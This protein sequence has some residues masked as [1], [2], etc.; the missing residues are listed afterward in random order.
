M[1]PPSAMP[2]RPR[3]ARPRHLVIIIAAVVLALLI[4]GSSI[5]GIY[6][7]MLW[8]HWGGLGEIWRLV[9]STKIVLEVIFFVVAFALMYGCLHLVDRV[10]D[11]S[12]FVTQESELVQHYRQSVARFRVWMRLGL[13]LLIAVILA[14]GTSGQWQHWL[15]YQHA[16]AFGH[17]DPIF[18]RDLS[19][20][21]FRMPFLSFLVDWVFSA[22]VVSVIIT[23]AS[24][25]LN[26]ALHI[27]FGPRR[28][29]RI[30][31]RAVAHI[32]LLLSL[33]ALERAWAYYFVDRFSLE[34]SQHGAVF[35]ATYT[36]VHVRL[37]A[38]TLLA[39]VSL[40]GFVLLAFNVYQRSITMPLIA[41]G[42]WIFL[43]ITIGA[44]YPSLYQA[45]KVTPDQ[46]SL[47]QP[48]IQRNIDATRAAMN[49][50]TITNQ[51]FPANQD[52]TA[53]VLSSY[54]QTLNDA[55]LWD[56]SPSQATYVKLQDKRSYYSL[57]PLVIDRYSLN[58]VA[59]P[60]DVG[61]REL[62]SNGVASQSWINVH[63]QYTH[64]YG[65]VVAPA[66]VVDASGN[67]TFALGNIPSI[68]TNS[69]VKIT[70]PDVYFAP[71]QSNYVIVDTKQPEVSYQNSSGGLVESSYSGSGGIPIDSLLPRLA[72]SIRF[73]DLNLLISSEIDSRSRLINIPNAQEAVQKALPFLTV[74]SNPYAVIDHGQ[75]NWLFDAY[76][77]SASYP[78][79]QPAETSVLP[80]QSALNGGYNYVR[81]AVKVVVNA[82]TGKMTF[83]TIN[84]KGD[85][86]MRSYEQ[87]FPHLFTPLS[88]LATTDP[89]LLAH[90]RYP[91]DLLMLQSAMY[92][93]YHITSP[94]AFYSLSN[95][96]DLSQTSTSSNGN[97]SASLPLGNN[98]LI[99]RYSPIYEL[100]QLPGQTAPSFNAIEPLVPYSAND[101][102][103][104]LAAL[105]L[106]DSSYSHYG[107][108]TAFQTPSGGTPIDGPQLVNAAINSNPTISKQISLLNQGG[109]T[110]LFGTVQI[111]PIADSLIYVRPLYVS[112]SQTNFPQL[113]E[114]VVDYGGQVA[115]EPTLGAALSDVFGAGVSSTSG[116]GSSATLPSAVRTLISNAVADYQAAQT[117][118]TQGSLATYQSDIEQAGTLIGQAESLLKGSG[119][120]KGSTGAK[121]TGSKSGSITT[122]VTTTTIKG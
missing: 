113:Q 116:V 48:Y 56:P 65:A 7:N 60:V 22:L 117:A 29:V 33:I 17:K 41:F 77:E 19:F 30:E 69:S 95:A 57:T 35:G 14:S 59:T 61:V 105:V 115:M 49:I 36:D 54:Q 74:D 78:Y 46:S 75:I 81:D 93:R 68:A 27:E 2:I 28:S 83:Y 96:W 76:T 3:L 32:S 18:G 82:Y 92:G 12:L 84:A 87:M 20:F 40:V 38:L 26:G 9:T 24:Y 13:S 37:P 102:V 21:V 112:S 71:G 100:L 44:I 103:Q 101:K 104:T 6:T 11:K 86:L 67:P 111:L 45:L 85:P 107:A 25:I 106:A 72:F 31:P 97:P 50:N 23:T 109:S 55:Q 91:Q 47:E 66:N 90:L 118:L 42:L 39:V 114:V 15:L 121:S 120:S 53:G 94:S 119:N 58:G 98:G 51:Y 79:A 1:R 108:L 89:T 5:A 99:E 52:L 43:A 64:G 110:V 122:T 88:T 80:G 70:Q 62:N 16:V 63:L 8:F 34:L 10:V 4:F 73:H